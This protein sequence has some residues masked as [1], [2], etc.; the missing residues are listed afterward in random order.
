VKIIGEVVIEGR[1]YPTAGEW[2]GG[3]HVGF[4]CFD[5][6]LVPS[7]HPGTP[8]KLAA[9]ESRFR[10]AP[11]QRPATPTIDPQVAKANATLAARDAEIAR[12]QRQAEMA[13]TLRAKRAEVANLQAEVDRRERRAAKPLGGKIRI[14]GVLSVGRR[15]TKT[16]EAAKPAESAEAEVPASGL[17]GFASKIRFA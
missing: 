8:V 3:A 6:W 2:T 16:F 1:R 14:G 13:E 4:A 15:K 11:A 12:L 17:S 9:G 10:P 7:G 5:G